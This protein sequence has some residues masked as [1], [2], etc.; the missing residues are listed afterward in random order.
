MPDIDHKLHELLNKELY[1][2]AF[3]L[4]HDVHTLYAR[5]T[6]AFLYQYGYG[7]DKNIEKAINILQQLTDESYPSSAYDLG[8]IYIHQKKDAKS[9]LQFFLRDE[10]NPSASYWISQI[11]DGFLNHEIDQDKRL[12]Y[13]N[14]SAKLGHVFAKRELLLEKFKHEGWI[15]L[16]KSKCIKIFILLEIFKASKNIKKLDDIIY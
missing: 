16:I 2:D 10:D 9:A 7:V 8:L 14:K 4:A 5:R 1:K 13:L 3:L 6:L 11:Y 12:H 15:G